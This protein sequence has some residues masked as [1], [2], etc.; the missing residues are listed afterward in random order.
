MRNPRD[1]DLYKAIEDPTIAGASGISTNE[2]NKI[3]DGFRATPDKWRSLRKSGAH[4]R[5]MIDN[6]LRNQRKTGL[7]SDETYDLLTTQWSNYVPLKGQEG[8]DDQG[9]WMPGKSGFDVRGQEFKTALGR[10]SEAENVIAHAIVQNE[11]S[12]LRQHKNTVGKSM[13]RFINEF[14]PTGE[15][16]A[17]VYWAGKDGLGDITKAADVYKRRIGK[18]GQ[19]EWYR[20]PNPFGNRDDV[21]AAKIGGKSYY[22][23]FH[24]PKVGLALRKMGQAEL[25]TLSKIVRPL[26]VWQSIVNT[27]ANPAF[28]PI[29]IIRDVQAGAVHLRTEGFSSLQV[30]GIVKNIPKAWGALWRQSRKKGG[31]SEW[32][33]YAREYFDAGGKITFH[34]YAT[35]E[36][37][38]KQ[39]EKQVAR[40]VDGEA[41]VKTS[42]RAVLKFIGDLNDAGENGIRLASYVAARKRGD[43]PKMSAFMARDLTVDFKKHGEM[44]PAMNAWYVSSTPRFRVR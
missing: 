44:G 7:I 42:F 18:S 36:D 2:A 25:G 40:S 26:T 41:A 21:L 20:Q 9:F 15:S 28:T 16:L 6:E 19:V 29:N 5:A 23:R 33:R 12:I 34:G 27:R 13:L 10:F 8:M 31:D 43:T 24:D 37:S 17:E 4:V 3:L 39:L 14:D 32:D 38:L 11:Q 22:I 30:G 1:S 35:L